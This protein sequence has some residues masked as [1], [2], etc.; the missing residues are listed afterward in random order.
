VD[1]DAEVTVIESRIMTPV[2]SV[3]QRDGD[4]ISEKIDGR[5]LPISRVAANVEKSFAGRNEKLVAH[6]QAP[7][8]A[9]NT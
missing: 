8:R 1:F 9:W 2:T 4:V 6:L 5:D 3:G 7:D